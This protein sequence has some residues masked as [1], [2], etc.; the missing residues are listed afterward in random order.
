MLICLN[1]FHREKPTLFF[2]PT[3]AG[4]QDT[5]A[6]ETSLNSLVCGNKINFSRWEKKK[7]KTSLLCLILHQFHHRWLSPDASMNTP[8]SLLCF[9]GGSCQGLLQQKPEEQPLLCCRETL[10]AAGSQPTVLANNSAPPSI[11]QLER[12]LLLL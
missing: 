4:G 10:I 2:G 6:A 12:G 5:W 7:N 11:F 9:S 1:L 3:P 8:A